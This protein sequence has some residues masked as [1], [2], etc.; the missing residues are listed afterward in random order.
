VLVS[1][2]MLVFQEVYEALVDAGRYMPENVFYYE[3]T[4]GIL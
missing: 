3:F 4:A 1:V 2:G